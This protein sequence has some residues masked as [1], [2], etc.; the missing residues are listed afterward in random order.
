[1]SDRVIKKNPVLRFSS[2][3]LIT[4]FIPALRPLLSRH[5]AW[6]LIIFGIGF[7]LSLALII[8]SN[9]RPYIVISDN[10]LFAYLLYKYK[11]E[12]HDLESIGEIR[13]TGPRTLVVDSK[14]FDPLDI[15]LSKRVMDQLCS[16]LEEKGLPI[17]RVY[18]NL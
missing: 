10:K 12:I 9:S 18:R 3:L 1:M 15:H 17:N 8:Y 14:G 16:L 6:E 4:P 7:I 11:P 5:N 13:Q 2:Y